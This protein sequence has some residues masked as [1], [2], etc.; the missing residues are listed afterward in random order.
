M[1]ASARYGAIGTLR[2]IRRDASA[3]RGGSAPREDDTS[4][5]FQVDEWSPML[6]CSTAPSLATTTTPKVQQQHEA[7]EKRGRG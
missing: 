7:R 4:E 6:R 1:A 5:G 3:S 2:M